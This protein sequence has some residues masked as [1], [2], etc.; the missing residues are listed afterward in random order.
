MKRVLV[1]ILLVIVVLAG[2]LVGRALT[3]SSKQAAGVPRAPQLKMDRH[4]A[5]ARFVRALQFRTISFGDAKPSV[6]VEH[7]QFVTWLATAYPRVHAS[8]SRELVGK[9]LVFVWPGW[10]KRLDPLLLMGHYDVVPIEPGTETRWEHPP[11]SGAI[12]GG[13]VW[14]R[15]TMDD[16]LT[17]IALLESAESLLAEG[18][19]PKRTIYFAFG[20]DEEA[21]G[22]GA[23]RVAKLLASRGVKFEAVI[24]EGGAILLDS[25]KG[26]PKPV[27]VIGI[28]E[29]GFAS[30]ELSAQGKGGHSSMPPARTEVGS[31]AA[32][33]DAVQS[34]P[35]PAGVRG[36]AAHTFRWLAPEMPFAQR[37]ALAN[38][39][40][41]EPA[42]KAQTSKSGSMNAMLR[43]TTAPT[44]I[45]GGVKDN[46]IPSH[47]RAVIN[48]RLLPGDSTA[49]V[50]A[51]VKEAVDDPHVGVKLTGPGSEP[52][53]VSNPDSPQFRAL[54]ETIAAVFPDVIVAPY[55]VVGATDARHFTPLSRSVFRFVPARITEADLAR[56]HGTNERIAVDD[57]FE[58]I[59]F[60]R[61]LIAKLAA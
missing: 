41:F 4:A 49:S 12:A 27:A 10:D 42:L 5:M 32:A 6:P 8:L 15:G 43:T 60:Y 36:A 53:P 51:H 7:D 48:F 39:W 23:A 11:F 58:A 29:K 21:G 25:I 18:F 46:V 20:E 13:Y 3:V 59:R 40:L 28:A 55:L 54:Q 47:A 31:V 17:V 16:K 22:A 33:V 30:V 45:S 37:V 34:N 24:D 52:S 35:F 61:A 44:I 14:G 9:S 38:L 50:L 26:A 57:Y 56:A 1:L 2:V 19:K